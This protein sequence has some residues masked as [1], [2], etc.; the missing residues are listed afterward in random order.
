MP[1]PREQHGFE[2]C[3]GRLYA[4]AGI[5][6]N[7]VETKRSYRYVPAED[8]WHRI[9]D[10]PQP[11]QSLGLECCRN[12]LYGLGGYDH[13]NQQ[14]G[15]T[16]AC[17]RYSPCVDSWE[18]IAP[19]HVAREDAGSLVLGGRIYV[20]GGVTNP[21]HAVAKSY[22]VYDPNADTWTIYAWPQTRCLGDWADGQGD[23]CQLLS[24]ISD[25]SKYP[26]FQGRAYCDLA[27]WR[28]E[29]IL[30]GGSRDSTTQVLV[31]V[32]A[33]DLRFGGSRRLPDLPYAARGVGVTVIGDSLYACGGWDGTTQRN[34]LHVL[35]VK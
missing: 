34:D 5:D 16:Q 22:E 10:Y 1:E 28:G 15:K 23:I 17:Y 30:V 20:F 32:D 9:A 27:I 13:R 31:T 19:M 14:A 24:G 18:P 33:V 12:Q 6:G 3:D 11:V 25:M 4:V 8:R 35:T 7:N 21:G 26:A 29:A 2:A